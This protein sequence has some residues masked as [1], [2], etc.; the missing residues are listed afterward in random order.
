MCV[1]AEVDPDTPSTPRRFNVV[2]SGTA[3]PE[4]PGSYL[5]M[6][7]L[8]GGTTVLHVYETVFT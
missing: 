5:G 3:P 4:M 7:L 6:V 1:W 8:Q 2:P